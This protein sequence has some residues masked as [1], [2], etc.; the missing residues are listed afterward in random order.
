MPIPTAA[1]PAIR[2]RKRSSRAFSNWWSGI[3]TRSGGTTDCS[4]RKSTSANSTTPMS[5]SCEPN[6]PKPDAGSGCST[7]PVTSAFQAYVAMSHSEAEWR[8][9]F[10]EFGSGSHFDARIALLR[11]LTELNQ[12]LSIGLMG[13]RDRELLE[14]RRHR[15][16]A[17]CRIIPILIPNGEPPSQAD[18]SSKFGA[19]DKRE[20][21]MACVEHRQ[22]RRPRLSGARP[23]PARHR[24][25]GRARHR[26]GFA[27]FLSPLRARP[28]L[29]CSGQV[30]MDRPAGAGERSQS[31]S[32]Q[33]LRRRFARAAEKR[34]AAAAAGNSFRSAQQPC[35][36]RSAR[37]AET[38]S[39]GSTACRCAL[40]QF[41]SAA[42]ERA[43][44]LNKGLPLAALASPRRTVDKEVD[45]LVRRLAAR[46][47]LEF[48]LVRPG[49]GR[50]AI[51]TW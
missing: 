30:G 29:R 32:S 23:D 27:A 35:H 22:A 45:L 39:Q 44:E 42:A 51:R 11:A 49:R 21:V 31:A 41:S 17:A 40:G 1:P 50:E 14:R 19:L 15:S 43:R 9:D 28:A 6:L 36:D 37:G 46:G 5:A 18:F 16:V 33:D 26:S 24:G 8:G 25:A 3:H 13:M 10:V 47:L 2:S 48:R 34:R 4:G 38:S 12:F 20:Q 7:S